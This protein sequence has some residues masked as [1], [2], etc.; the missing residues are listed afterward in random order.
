MDC[1]KMHYA[2]Q[3]STYAYMLQKRN[4]DLNIKKL[5]LI[6]YDHDGNV[7]N[8][9]LPYLKDEVV[10]MC[11]HYIEQKEIEYLEEKRKPIIF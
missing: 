9:E 2:L 6:H 11:R 1:N 5:M 4:P 7:T 3:L 8:H 10:L